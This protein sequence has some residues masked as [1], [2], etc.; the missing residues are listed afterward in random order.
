[1]AENY[2]QRIINC[3]VADDEPFARLGMAELIKKIP[4]F[5]LVGIAK[6]AFEV[7]GYLNTEEVHLLFLDIQ[8]PKL[9]GIEL[10]RTLKDPPKVIFT[11]AYSKY[12]VDGYELD[13]LDYLLKPVTWERF[14]KAANK[15]KEYFDLDN[16]PANTRSKEVDNIFFFIKTNKKLEK[17]FF[18]EI[19][20]IEAM[21]NYVI[22]H[23]AGGKIITYSSIKKILDELPVTGFLKV[24]KSYI[25]SLSKITT[26]DG[27]RV[28]IQQQHIP[29]SR[30]HKDKLRK[31]ILTKN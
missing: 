23:T 25:V 10:L 30:P 4:F 9:T 27:N 3:L 26:V 19:L 24:H 14:L 6:D 13:I 20:F 5:K 1:M 21:L 2:D 8:M 16:H 22:I 15:A 17:I 29:V 12:A 28:R 31:A 18:D 11:T 7:I